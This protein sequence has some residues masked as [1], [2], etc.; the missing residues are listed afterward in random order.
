MTDDEWLADLQRRLLEHLR[1][2]IMAA[3]SA[4]TKKKLETGEVIT[5]DS[6]TGTRLE[7][8]N[9]GI[10]R[11]G[12]EIVVPEKMSLAEARVWLHRR[13][14][15]ENETVAI[16]EVID[17]FPLEGAY[18]FSKALARTYGF[19][20]LVATPTFFGKR[21]PHMIGIQVSPTDT[22]Q[23]PWGRI[24][25]PAF[26]GGFLN[27]G[28]TEK[29]KRLSFVIAG[30][31]R[32]KFK[33]DVLALANLTRQIVREESVYRGKAIRVKF[34]ESPDEYDITDCPKFIETAGV[35]EDE[36]I[37]AD[38]VRKQVV[39]SIFTPIEQTDNCRKYRIPL[40]R[41]IL[42]EGPFGVGKT[43]TANV[44]AKKCV[45]N[46]WTFIY[47]SSVS[48]LETAIHFAKSYQPAV[49]F[50]EDVDRVMEGERDESMDEI[51]NTIDGV[52]TKGME[53]MVVLTTNHVENIEPAMMRPGRLDAVISVSAP[54]ASAVRSLIQLYARGQLEATADLRIVGEKLT[55]QIP[56]VIRE[57][58]ERS[59]LAAISRMK[60]GD[61]L[62]LSASDLE[63]AASQMLNHIALMTPKPE[64][65]RSKF[66]KAAEILGQ[67][68]VGKPP[69]S[70]KA[71]N[72]KPAVATA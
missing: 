6:A 25:I 47:L 33:N 32:Q 43:L 22:E 57:V 29:N 61:A 36:L 8:D 65:K 69:A 26:E 11:A 12:V 44:T 38:D 54:D 9:V 70:L 55:G 66:E 67:H 56:A 59:K 62:T 4:N 10:Q 37:F 5:V 60:P 1:G 20:S 17:A 64:D 58:V 31:V 34:P 46:G 21:P 15:E 13:E 16:H 41:G 50:A 49:I 27:T 39:T 14:E 51:L 53:L 19:V 18:A 35:R 71:T 63:I 72:G 68:I 2:Q 45:E 23:V 30:E 24:E 48:E 3:K 42:L 7:H 52:D 40:K 28:V